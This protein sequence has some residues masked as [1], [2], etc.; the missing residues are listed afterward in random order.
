MRH[1][2]LLLLLCACH[3]AP[4]ETPAGLARAGMEMH[5]THDYPK[6]IDYYRRSLALEASP[7]VRGNLARALTASGRY[8]E[9]VEQYEL[10]IA[11]DSSNGAIWHE[12]GIA[13]RDGIKDMKA[14]EEALFNATRYP[15]KP[16]EANYDLG[17]L[18]LSSGRYEEAAACLEASISFGSPK[19]PWYA[20][21]GD[22]LAQAH[23]LRAK[24]AAEKPPPK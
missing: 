22:R 16:P 21:A 18:L 4:P 14:A 8:P 13:L 11:A 17:C 23:A 10:L 3:K 5:R 12:Y 6:A 1:W 19:A 7:G 9:A 24:A 20:D 15:P 2:I